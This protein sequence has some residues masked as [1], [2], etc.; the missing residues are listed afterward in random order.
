[1]QQIRKMAPPPPVRTAKV[2]FLKAVT[3][4]Q[5]QDAMP[6][7]IF[8]LPKYMATEFVSSGFAEYTDEGDR[9]EHDDPGADAHRES[10]QTATLEPPTS[11]DP[12]P[13]KKG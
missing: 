11:R 6:G 9:S 3:L 1:M 12:K 2:K 10:Y 8:E 5:N 4:G 13:K 7:D